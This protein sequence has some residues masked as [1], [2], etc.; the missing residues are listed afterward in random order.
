M[1][2]YME[3]SAI[4]GGTTVARFSFVIGS[5]LDVHC[6][7]WFV[8]ETRGSTLVHSVINIGIGTAEDT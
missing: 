3:E 6:V 2:C 1:G 8:Y 4:H 5:D 7:P